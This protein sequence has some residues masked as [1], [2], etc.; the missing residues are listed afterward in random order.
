MKVRLLLSI[1]AFSFGLLIVLVSL[2]SIE[3][4]SAGENNTS[5]KKLYMGQV[6][7]DHIAYPLLMAMDRFYLETSDD[8]ERIYK[9][10]EYANR[11]L[12]YT[13][14]LLAQKD[15]EKL[16]LALSTLT[17]AEKYLIKASL[18]SMEIEPDEGIQTAIFRSL[19]YHYSQLEELTDEFT[20]SQRSILDQLKTEEKSL[21][22]QL[23]N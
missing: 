6:L 15:T 11:R 22:E 19:Q 18:E 1:S 4:V 2:M 13:Q 17:K 10:I 7:P 14:E 20:D 12:F 9:Q 16:P 23:N 3:A 5:S 21:I 8:K